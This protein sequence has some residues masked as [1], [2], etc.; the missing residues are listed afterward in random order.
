[1]GEALQRQRRRERARR[2][3]ADIAPDEPKAGP[4]R[5][6]AGPVGA[7]SLATLGGTGWAFAAIAAALAATV[8]LA[9]Q[10]AHTAEQGK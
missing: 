7:A 4:G 1:M 6:A 8:P 5:R 9:W 3:A 10:L 2:R